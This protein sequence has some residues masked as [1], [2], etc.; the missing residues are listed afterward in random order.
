MCDRPATA[1]AA[2][3]HSQALQGDGFR[4][5]QDD[6]DVGDRFGLSVNLDFAEFLDRQQRFIEV[7]PA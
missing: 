5:S 6:L 2:D 3:R 1:G 7:C 4:P